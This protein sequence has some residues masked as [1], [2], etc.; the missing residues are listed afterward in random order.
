MLLRFKI[1]RPYGKAVVE[2]EV[3]GD[4]DFRIAGIKRL[5]GRINL[6]PKRWLKVVRGHI[7]R[8]ERIVKESGCCELRVAGR[9][10]KRIL[11]DY[12]PY[13]GVPNRLRKVL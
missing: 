8:I 3:Y 9:D 6:P 2:L 4:G 5:K 11:T 7:H 12:E 10:W 13:D 1:R